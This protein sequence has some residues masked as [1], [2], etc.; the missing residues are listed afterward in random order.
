M[1]L[2]RNPNDVGDRAVELD[3]EYLAA[4]VEFHGQVTV[5]EFNR[6]AGSVSRA[7]VVE[8]FRLGLLDRN[9]PGLL[10]SDPGRLY[11]RRTLSAGMLAA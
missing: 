3:A 4:L 9:R 2:Y 6:L 10:D 1:R 8:A 7:A 5:V 11:V